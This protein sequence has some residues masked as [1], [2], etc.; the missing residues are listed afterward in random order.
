MSRALMPVS[1]GSAHWVAH[2]VFARAIE[3]FLQREREGVNE[4]LQDLKSRT[5]LRQGS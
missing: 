2:P 5:P 3:D 4:Y 1:T